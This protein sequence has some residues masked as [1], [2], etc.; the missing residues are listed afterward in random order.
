[1]A[2]LEDEAETGEVNIEEEEEAAPLK[3]AP[4]PAQPSEEEVEN[5]RVSHYP[6]R[7]WCKWCIMGR[8]IGSPH[9][10]STGSSIPRIGMD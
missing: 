3:H 9:R 5:H 2:P 4:D 7:T 1:M 6:F 10:S 8:G